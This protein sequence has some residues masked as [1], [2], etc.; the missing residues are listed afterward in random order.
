[1]TS[2]TPGT[3]IEDSARSVETMI[4]VASEMLSVKKRSGLWHGLVT[5]D[6]I[7]TADENDD[8]KSADTST[9]ALQRN[10][11]VERVEPGSPAEAGG[12]FL[13]DTLVAVAGQPV[14]DVDDLRRYLRAGETVTVRV[15]RGG[16]PADLAVTVGADKG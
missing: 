5:R 13:G 14:Q 2:R 1:M 3:V 8:I 16:Q 15:L 11:L 12:L 6:E 10:L 7:I 9:A 4:R